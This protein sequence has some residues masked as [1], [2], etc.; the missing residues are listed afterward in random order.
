MLTIT[1]YS[2]NFTPYPREREYKAIFAEDIGSASQ[3]DI[4]K[5][6]FE[7]F[8]LFSDGLAIIDNHTV[9]YYGYID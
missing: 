2:E 9:E 6:C 3:A 8:R 7:K 1:S 5:A 4:K